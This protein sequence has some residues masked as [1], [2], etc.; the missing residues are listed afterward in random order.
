[1]NIRVK[2]LTGDA[3]TAALPDLARLRIN[4]FS[5][6]PYLYQGD[7]AYEARYLCAYRTTAR[8]I[9]IAAFDGDKIIGA[10]T[11]MPLTDHGDASQ[12]HGPTPNPKTIFYCAESVL[13]PAY[14]GQGLGHRFFDLREVHARKLNLSH[15]AFCAVIRPHDHPAMPVNYRPLDPFWRARGYAPAKG[16]TAQFSWT[17]IGDSVETPKSLQFWMKPL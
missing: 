2:A 6:F 10:A 17:D 12:I 1:M 11:G 8:A 14:R 15:S 16:V 13:L 3:L 9:L 5:A 4:V 7:E